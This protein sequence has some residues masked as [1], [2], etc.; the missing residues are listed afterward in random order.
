LLLFNSVAASHHH[1]HD[2]HGISPIS[3][4]ALLSLLSF[5]RRAVV[6]RGLLAVTPVKTPFIRFGS[7]HFFPLL[8]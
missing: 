4:R 8:Q 1:D 3:E 6:K 5:T 7:R 2:G